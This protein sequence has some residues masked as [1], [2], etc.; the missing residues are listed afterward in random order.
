M[1][2]MLV[3]AISLFIGGTATFLTPETLNQKLPNNLEDAEKIWGKPK[4]DEKRFS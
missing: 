2:P 1:V 4:D 3:M